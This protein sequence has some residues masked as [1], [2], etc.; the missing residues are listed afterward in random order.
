MEPGSTAAVW[1]LGGVGLSAVMGCKAAGATRIIGIDI[2]PEKFATGKRRYL[3][4]YGA[5]TQH[6][7][8]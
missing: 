7:T 1:G 6:V 5:N 8:T 2:K 3:L 4:S